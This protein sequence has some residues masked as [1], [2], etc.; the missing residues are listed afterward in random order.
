MLMSDRITCTCKDVPASVAELCAYCR[1]EYYRTLRVAMMSAD[2]P[3][4]LRLTYF[5]ELRP[6]RTRYVQ[7][8]R[9]VEKLEAA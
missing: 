1:T 2:E 5:G 8:G 3:I 6:Y 7:Y 9:I 4:R